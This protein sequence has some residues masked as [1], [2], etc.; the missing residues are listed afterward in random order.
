MEKDYIAYNDEGE[1]VQ[2]GQM[3]EELLPLNAELTG[4]KFLVGFGRPYSHRVDLKTQTI[5]QKDNVELPTP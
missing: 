2:W 3:R 1:I 5:V 4:L